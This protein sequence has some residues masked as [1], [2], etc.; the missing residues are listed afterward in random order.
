MGTNI[1]HNSKA[2]SDACVTFLELGMTPGKEPSEDS[3]PLQTVWSR[4]NRDLNQQTHIVT[5]C[6]F[7]LQLT[8]ILPNITFEPSVGV[9]DLK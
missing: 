4:P 8:F 2:Q 7:N 6:E 1:F 3:G 9:R 5:F